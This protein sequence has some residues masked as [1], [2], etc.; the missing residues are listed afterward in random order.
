MNNKIKLLSVV[1]LALVAIFAMGSVANALDIEIAGVE[2][3]RRPLVDGVSNVVDR[4]GTVDVRVYYIANEDV[5]NAEIRLTL[6]GNYHKDNVDV[7]SSKINAVAGDLNHVDL[8]LKIPARFDA[9]Y[10]TLFVDFG[11]R[12]S[13]VTQEYVLRVNAHNH[14]VVINDVTLNPFNGV[15]AGRST[16]ARINVR[17]FGISDEDNMKVEFEIPQLNVKDSFR[18]DLKAGESKDSEDLYVRIP[19]CTKPG[20]YTA[21]ARVIYY[22]GDEV[23]EQKGTIE[24]FASEA[25]VCGTETTTPSEKEGKVVVTLGSQFQEVTQAGAIYPITFSNDGA[26]SKTFVVEVVGAQSWADVRISP[27]QTVTIGAGQTENVYVYVASKEGAPAGQKMFSVN[28]KNTDGETVK[29]VPLT[30]DVVAEEENS[31]ALVKG[32]QV[33]LIVLVILLVILGLVV[34]FNK[35]KSDEED[36]DSDD[37]IAGQTYY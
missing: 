36:E 37:E 30:A 27:L 32:L 8:K 14:R 19:Q 35:M 11:A 9:D 16:I 10:F 21:I 3:N 6:Y 15:E 33:G 12:N 2:V 24:V 26:A 17:N 4:D 22:D 29:Q 13:R 28:I 7:I 18:M 25:D 34:A 1:M 31:N 23:A 20:V 5:N